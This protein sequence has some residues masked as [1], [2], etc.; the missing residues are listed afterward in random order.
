MMDLEYKKSI[1]FVTKCIT[2]TRNIQLS[3]NEFVTN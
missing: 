1:G 3:Q 2:G